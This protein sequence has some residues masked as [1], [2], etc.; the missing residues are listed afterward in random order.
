MGTEGVCVD[1]NEGDW[2]LDGVT[3]PVYSSLANSMVRAQS[4]LRA[5]G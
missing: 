4:N 1:L 2:H 3:A 5:G